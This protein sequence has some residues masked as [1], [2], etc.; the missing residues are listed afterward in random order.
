MFKK[1]MSDITEENPE[2]GKKLRTL[3]RQK[4]G[5][6]RIKEDKPLLLKSIVDI[7]TES[8]A[9]DDRRHIEKLSS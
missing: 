3:N 1:K 2:V 9:T 7:I 4:I 6:P 8:A 5:H